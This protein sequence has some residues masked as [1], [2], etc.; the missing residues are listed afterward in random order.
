M[1]T[2]ALGKMRRK[3]A[4]D[5]FIATQWT[6]IWRR[7]RRHRLAMIGT[8]LVVLFYVIALFCEFI[9]TQD[10]FKRDTQYIHVPPQRIRLVSPYGVWPYVHG[11]KLEED[12]KTWRKIYT[13]DTSVANF[14][15]FFV[16]GD[17]YKLWGVFETDIHLF[18]T[19]DGPMYL[20]G[21]DDSGRDMFSRVLYGIRISMSVGLVGVI[22]TFI[23]GSVLGAISG[24]YGGAVDFVI[25]RIIEFIL[26]IP[27]IPLWMALSAALPANWTVIQ[28]YFGITIILSLIGWTG[29]AR[30]VR[31]R[32][33]ALREEDFVLA[34]RLV[35]SS[36]MRIILRHMVPSFLSYIIA[37]LTLAIPG[38]ILAE[39][40]LSF[41]A[42]RRQ[43][44][45]MKAVEWL[46]LGASVGE[47]S[48]R[49]GYEGPSAFVAG[50]R[51]AFGVTPGRYFGSG[52]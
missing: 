10:P 28:V 49:L 50:F 8:V 40:G 33:L 35:G 15:F 3:R 24:Y 42:W 19:Q 16:K 26:C 44:R 51:K 38:M 5:P 18:G 6:L 2:I 1:A 9:A 29:L 32:F 13:E 37:A 46:S 45:L 11:L 39:T 52:E 21:S 17:P 4:D 14:I 20:F 48:E 31:G 12:P 36:E 43:A 34:A 7:F 25:Q 22:F 23:L 30:V 27:A 41:R 47:V